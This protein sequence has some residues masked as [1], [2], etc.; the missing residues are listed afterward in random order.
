[1]PRLRQSQTPPQLCHWRHFLQKLKVV[2]PSHPP[3]APSFA[4]AFLSETTRSD[5]SQQHAPPPPP[6]P[7]SS[8]LCPLRRNPASHWIPAAHVR[9]YWI[10][11][12]PT[13]FHAVKRKQRRTIKNHGLP[14]NM[15]P[16]VFEGTNCHWTRKTGVKVKQS[17][18]E[19]VNIKGLL[20]LP[21]P[22]E[23]AVPGWSSMAP[24]RRCPASASASGTARL[25][26]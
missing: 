7:P 1:M 26:S 24:R 9:T 2:N 23:T 8:Q 15:H 18:S 5:P 21:A 20:Q 14:S 11:L 12:D 17:W 6:P 19:K 16:L 3:R 4:L 25:G 10:P 22:R 13:R